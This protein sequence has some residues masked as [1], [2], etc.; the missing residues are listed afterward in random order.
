MEVYQYRAGSG[1]FEFFTAELLGAKLPLMLEKMVNIG[2][3]QCA[4]QSVRDRRPDERSWVDVQGYLEIDQ[5]WFTIRTDQDVGL[6]VQIEIDDVLAVDVPE[7]LTQTVE[8]MVGDFVGVLEV[9]TFDVFVEQGCSPVTT[10]EPGG[11]RD[12]F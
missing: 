10:E 11:S 9:L 12:V 5:V 4:E 3:L 2:L 1:F 6:F 7:Q 8:E